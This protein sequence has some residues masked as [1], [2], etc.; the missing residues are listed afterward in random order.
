MKPEP[1]VVFV[2]DALPSIGGGEKVLF[3][4]LEVF[5][6]ADVF[7]LI[8]NRPAFACSPLAN[9]KVKTSLLDQLPLAHKHH[10]LFLPLMPSAIERFDLRGY[11]L[12]VSFSYAVAHGA[13]SS[14]GARHVS[15][16]YTPM[17]AC[18]PSSRWSSCAD[19]A[20]RCSMRT[21]WNI[22][23][24]HRDMAL[25]ISVMPTRKLRRRSTGRRPR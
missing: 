21:A 15:Y 23:T 16:T 3:T 6:C 25:P 8:Y 13:F 22:W 2:T 12:I 5:P 19:K 7:T 17:L 14:N 18:M 20:R 11:D 9:R 4:A 10:R 1:R 24:A